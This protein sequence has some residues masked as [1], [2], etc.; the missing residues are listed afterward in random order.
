MKLY[1]LKLLFYKNLLTGDRHSHECFL[2]FI[3]FCGY[4]W[5]QLIDLLKIYARAVVQ[6]TL[7]AHLVHYCYMF[8][9]NLT[10]H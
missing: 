4:T 6:H 8:Q 1:M 2:V 7:I 10:Q 3:W 9:V 5:D